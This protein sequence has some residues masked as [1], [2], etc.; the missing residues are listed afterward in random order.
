MCDS[1]KPF[2]GR[3]LLVDV[4][5]SHELCGRLCLIY[6]QCQWITLKCIDSDMRTAPAIIT[7]Q[8]DRCTVACC[9]SAHLPLP[10]A[11]R[12]SL[13]PAG[14]NKHKLRTTAN[15][16]THTHTQTP[17]IIIIIIIINPGS[18]AYSITLC[19]RDLTLY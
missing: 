6:M 15:T 5:R 1:H 16:H 11:P 9:S 7:R 12:P 14:I 18:L 17:S 19:C 8:I 2:N 10:I 4:F 3:P 13:P